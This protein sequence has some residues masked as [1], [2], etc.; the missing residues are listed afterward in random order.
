M[1]KGELVQKQTDRH[2]RTTRSTVKFFIFSTVT[3]G[4]PGPPINE[5]LVIIGTE[6]LQAF[7]L[8]SNSVVALMG[9]TDMI[10]A[11]CPD[12]IDDNGDDD[13]GD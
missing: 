7:L 9:T 4:G 6:F 12:D 8:P 10:V 13:G 2:D 1:V 5:P 3:R 11:S